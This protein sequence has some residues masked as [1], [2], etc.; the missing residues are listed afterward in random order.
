M[1]YSGS[2]SQAGR[3]SLLS[4]GA[5]PTEIGEVSD[6][7]FTRPQWDFVDVT[8]FDSAADQEML[9]TIRK[10]AN[11][12]VKGNRVSSD[13]GQALVET[14]YQSGALTAFTLTL[15]KTAAQTTS[16]DKYTFNAYV[17]TFGF[18]VTPTKQ[19]EFS[20]DLQTSGPITFT[21][22]T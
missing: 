11:F 20:L 13:A 8:N 19:I 16:G 7:P 18:D 1:T 14:A 17:R 21:I 4:I 2:K 6:V 15:P 9:S 5:T 22:G 12:T 10:A 3:G